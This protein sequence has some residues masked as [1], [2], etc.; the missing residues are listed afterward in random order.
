MPLCV[1]EYFP[2][3]FRTS[4]RQKARWTLGIA[5]QGWA[6]LGWA[7]TLKAN[8]FFVRDRKAIVTPALS[9]ASY[10]ILLNFMVYA[11]WPGAQ[12]HG[13]RP[14]F[15]DQWWILPL[16]VFNG[17]ALALRTVQRL[18]FVNRFYGWEHAL[19]SLPRM[20][21]ATIVNLWAAGRATRIFFANLMFGSG[22]VWDKTMHD[23]PTAED[24]G[25]ERRALGE[26]L[27]DWRA[28]TPE[29]VA[30]ALAIQARDGQPLGRILQAR[31]W[32]DDETLAEAIS[33]QS[34]L[35]RASITTAGLRAGLDLI[36]RDVAIAHRVAP[37]ERTEQ[38]LAVA[39]ARPLSPEAEQAL[40]AAGGGPVQVRIARESEITAGLVMLAWSLPADRASG[41]GLPQLLADEG[42]LPA[43]AFELMPV[44]G[45]RVGEVIRSSGALAAAATRPQD[46]RSAA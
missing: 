20:F 44:S 36:P 24:L 14:V 21:V 45:R 34:D 15:P 17:V 35:P 30:E 46:L 18:Y 5:Y 31:G 25:H 37:L 16:I 12:A 10:V 38:G 1:R 11:A 41:L 42:L 39:A 33:V 40:G 7:D 13:F 32:L 23:F 2:N 3:T 6:Q 29:Q 27:V 4:Y 26:I 19:L 28:V 22:I 8:Y 43:G 9:L